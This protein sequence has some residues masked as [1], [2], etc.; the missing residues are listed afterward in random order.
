RGKAEKAS[1]L[2]VAREVGLDVER[3]QRDMQAPEITRRIERS[4]A[5]ADEIGLVGTPSFI[6]GDR[7]IFGY[8]RKE[9]L[10]ELVAEARG[11]R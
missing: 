10:A 11:A 1:V 3:L 4:L 7:A 6:A 5:L 2:R 8:L 9:D